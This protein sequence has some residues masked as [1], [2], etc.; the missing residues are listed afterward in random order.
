VA[1]DQICAGGVKMHNNN[2]DKGKENKGIQIVRMGHLKKIDDANYLVQ[3]QSNAEIWYK[4]QWE[5]NH[6]ICSC[7]DYEKHNSKCKHIH[8]AVYYQTLTKIKSGVEHRY[9]EENCPICGLDDQVV[10]DGVRYN[11]SGPV[12]RYFCKRC[13]KR[14]AERVTGFKGMKNKPEIV[15]ASLDLFYRGLSLRQIVQHLETSQR[16][17]ISYGTIYYWIKKYVDLVSQYTE[18]LT[19]NLSGKLH[20]D[21]TVLTVSG[22]HLLLW[23]LLDSETRFLVATHISQKRGEEDAS[24]LLKKGKNASKG[25]VTEIVTD[26]LVSYNGAIRNEFGSDPENPLIHLQGPLSLGLNNKMERMNETIKTRTKTMAG[27]YNEETAIRFANGFLTHYNFVRTHSALHNMT[28]AMMAG[29]TPRK[30]DWLDLIVK[31]SKIKESNRFEK[32]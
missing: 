32:D 17:K 20:A 10:K 6:W 9:K 22:R 4:V 28:P 26:G 31:S 14:Y 15:A 30:Y 27:L 25:K 12:Q 29:I 1:E 3:S 18:G 23:S 2:A 5:K 19:A 24:A 7:P 8:A 21:E 13:K 16:I 11:R